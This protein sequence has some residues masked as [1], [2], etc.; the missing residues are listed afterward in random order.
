MKYNMAKILQGRIGE[1]D[2]QL[3]VAVRK[4]QWAKVEYLRKEKKRLEGEL[5]DE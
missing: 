4:K 3:A 1:I 2:K 5:K